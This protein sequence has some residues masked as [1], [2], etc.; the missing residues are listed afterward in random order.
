M[1][2]VTPW[3]LISSNLFQSSPGLEAGCDGHR[4]RVCPRGVGFNPHP[5]WRPG[6]TSQHLPAGRGACVSILTRLGGRVR[7]QSLRRMSHRQM[8][9]SSPG[10]EAGCD[11]SKVRIVSADTTFQSSPGLEAGCDSARS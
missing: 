5:A 6:A 4:F 9:Q 8:F 3:S 1:R 7:Q 10:L 11:S 2:L